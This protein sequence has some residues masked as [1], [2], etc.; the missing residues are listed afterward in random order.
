MKV[1]DRL[2][3]FFY[4]QNLLKKVKV[5]Y[6]NFLEVLYFSLEIPIPLTFCTDKKG[7]WEIYNG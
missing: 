3:N 6:K 1:Q 2:A 5:S 7:K 4:Q